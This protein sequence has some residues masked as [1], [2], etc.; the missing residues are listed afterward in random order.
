[1]ERLNNLGLIFLSPGK[2]AQNVAADP[3]WLIPLV[4]VIAVAFVFA[5]L[6]HEYQAE[7]FLRSDPC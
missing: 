1:M 4:V 2:V 6:A 7:D 5:F 3:H